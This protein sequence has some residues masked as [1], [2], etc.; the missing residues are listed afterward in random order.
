MLRTAALL[1]LILPVPHAGAAPVAPSATQAAPNC[2]LAAPPAGAGVDRH[3][4]ALLKVYPRGPDIGRAYSGCQT[5]WLQS[6][7]GWETLTVLHYANGRVARVE[8]PAVPHDP[9]EACLVRN[10]IVEQGD[11]ELCGQL[12]DMRIESLPAACLDR[13]DAPQCIRE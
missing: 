4:G 5:L 9:V 8:N 1:A 6:G 10:G 7:D 12:D 2:A 3:M 13:P 11:P